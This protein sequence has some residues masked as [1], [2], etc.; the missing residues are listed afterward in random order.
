MVHHAA[1]HGPAVQPALLE[2]V[3]DR[4]DHTAVPR[5]DGD[6]LGEYC[7]AGIR[8]PEPGPRPAQPDLVLIADRLHDGPRARARGRRRG[9]PMDAPQEVDVAS[10]DL[11]DAAPAGRQQARE[12]VDDRE[13]RDVVLLEQVSRLVP[14]SA[15]RPG[16]DHPLVVLY[17][18]AHAVHGTARFVEH[19]G[20]RREVER[21]SP[22]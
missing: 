19:R 13:A 8:S 14:D 2:R 22:V 12:D 21:V 10:G 18:D 6:I 11:Q 16:L 4:V 5:R 15:R 17:G 1:V 7:L 3:Q 9:S 20:R